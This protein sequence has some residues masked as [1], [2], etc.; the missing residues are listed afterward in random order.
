MVNAYG[1]TMGYDL[2]RLG[3]GW[4]GGYNP[5]TDFS[6]RVPY[7]TNC[8][9]TAPANNTSAPSNFTVTGAT[10]RLARTIPSWYSWSGCVEARQD[11]YEDGDQ[12]EATPATRA[13]TRYFWPSTDNTRVLRPDANSNSTTYFDFW[14]TANLNE[15]DD[16]L[17]M[18]NNW[19]STN[20]NSRITPNRGCGA[21]S[22][23]PLQA[24][25]TTAE[26][27]INAMTPTLVTSYTH[28][29]LGLAWALRVLSPNYRG[30]WQS[31][32][33]NALPGD[34]D[35]DL[36]DKVVVLLT[37]GRNTFGACTATT[38]SR[39]DCGNTYNNYISAYT[40]YGHLEANYTRLGT[41]SDE[42]V[43]IASMNSRVTALCEQMKT[44]RH[45]IIYTIL[46]QE[47]DAATQTVFQNCATDINHYFLSPTAADL[48]GI[49]TTIANQLRRLRISR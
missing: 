35:P 30:L 26:T 25:R 43:A 47:N 10:A 39:V 20:Y 4:T 12:A 45:I 9:P 49:F 16:S 36:R 21:V 27:A 8:I 28:S 5:T 6:F 2:S 46:L 33:N 34:Y 19:T 31:P 44:Q 3:Y 23:V 11:P 29:N 1:T 13:F 7:Y 41:V 22:I 17:P 15:Y 48:D 14:S 32:S 38:N 37:D 42:S 18:A 40:A 24:D